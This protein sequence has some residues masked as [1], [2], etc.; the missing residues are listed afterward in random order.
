MARIT[1]Y[2]KMDCVNNG[3]QLKILQDAGNEVEVVDILA[4][5]WTR[6]ELSGFLGAKP[7]A[8]CIN[9]TAPAVKRGEIDPDSI[10][11]EKAVKLMLENHLL[12][13]RP[14]IEVDGLKIQGFLSPELKPYLGG[15]KNEEDVTSCPNIGKIGTK[16]AS[17][18]KH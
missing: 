18:A 4:H 10:G 17:P 3:K 5:E 14:L 2:R 6:E 13:K 7:I 16:C 12:I 8:D 11:R 1:F 9:R 15:W